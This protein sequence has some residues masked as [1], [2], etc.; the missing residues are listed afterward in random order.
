MVHRVVCGDARDRD[1]YDKLLGDKKIDLVFT[2]PPYNID[3]G[4]KEKT[5][6]AM[7]PGDRKKGH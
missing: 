2:D 1:V 4:G 7:R 6:R 3:I 5:K